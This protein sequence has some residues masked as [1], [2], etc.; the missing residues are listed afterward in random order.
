[1]SSGGNF[2]TGA[3][4]IFVLV[5]NQRALASL[6]WLCGDRN[7]TLKLASSAGVMHALCC[8]V[9]RCDSEC[10]CDERGAKLH[11]SL[12]Q[13][14]VTDDKA[15]CVLVLASVSAIGKSC[16]AA[17]THRYIPFAVSVISLILG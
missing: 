8:C 9:V 13:H 12:R 14:V 16:C 10:C 4:A 17:A 2:L 5:R 3:P 11:R 7:A 1:M 6:C 15:H